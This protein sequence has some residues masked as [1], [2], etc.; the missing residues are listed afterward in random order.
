MFGALLSL[1][2]VEMF[3]K[4]TPL[5]RETHFEI[6]S[7][8]LTASDHFWKLRR[9]RSARR[10]GAKQKRSQNE[11]N[12]E[13][14]ATFRPLLETLHF[15][16]C[17]VSKRMPGMERLKISKHSCRVAG[18]IQ[19]TSDM[20]GGQGAD[21]LKN[22][23]LEHQVFRFVKWILR[24]KC[25]TSYNPA[26]LFV[27]SENANALIRGGQ[28][29]THFHFGK[30]SRKNASLLMLSISKSEEILQSFIVLKEE[31]KKEK[32]RERERIRHR[33]SL[34][35][36]SISAFA[37]PPM[38]HNNSPRIVSYVWNFLNFHHRLVR[39]YW[40]LITVTPPP[41]RSNRSG[42]AEMGWLELSYVLVV[43][44]VGEEFHLHP[45]WDKLVPTRLQPSP[46]RTFQKWV[47]YNSRCLPCEPLW[48]LQ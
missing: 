33:A 36:R 37:L 22:S 6:K 43:A 23:I 18:A 13:K 8:E 5:W 1:L 34:T 30:K 20:L 39:H 44:R 25:T 48:T 42:T 46:K 27:A 12:I 38:H 4:C 2:D 3:K 14:H 24:D 19:E 47:G 26:L 21:F 41:I 40:Y 9:Q 17:A 31:R 15:W 28:F 45:G 16:W 7:V 32:E 29:C 10:C 11:K 35:F